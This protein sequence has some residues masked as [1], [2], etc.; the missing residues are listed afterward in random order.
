MDAL[1]V[2]DVYDPTRCWLSSK[3]CGNYKAE[4]SILEAITSLHCSLYVCITYNI[5]FTAFVYSNN[6]IIGILNLF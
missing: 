5:P 1:G 3:Q 2:S 4:V 6:I